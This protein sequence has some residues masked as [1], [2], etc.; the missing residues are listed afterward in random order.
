M[1]RL[2]QANDLHLFAVNTGSLYGAHLAMAR[3]HDPIGVWDQHMEFAV[4]PLYRKEFGHVHATPRTLC[5]AAETTKA[6]YERHIA[7]F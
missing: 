1:P 5:D 3:G 6:Y 4:L 2:V 7:E